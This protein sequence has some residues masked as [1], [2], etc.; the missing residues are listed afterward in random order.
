MGVPPCIWSTFKNA[1][2][3]AATAPP[4]FKAQHLAI[5]HGG[6]HE[7]LSRAEGSRPLQKRTFA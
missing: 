4:N 6:P 3:L 7:I 5:A 2:H 1:S